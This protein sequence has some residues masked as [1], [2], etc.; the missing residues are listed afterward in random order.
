MLTKLTCK[1]KIYFTTD[2]PR[3]VY[4]MIQT[5]NSRLYIIIMWVVLV[6]CYHSTWH[7]YFFCCC[8]CQKPYTCKSVDT[9]YM[10]RLLFA[11]TEQRGFLRSEEEE[12]VCIL[13]IMHASTSHES[14]LL[15]VWA[16]WAW[17]DFSDGNSKDG[18]RPTR[19]EPYKIGPWKYLYLYILSISRC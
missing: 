18:P 2:L 5:V 14:R 4:I 3:F 10:R 1:S 15:P 8:E 9:S 13:T 19:F 6:V 12:T 16:S 7:Y 11:T 17:S